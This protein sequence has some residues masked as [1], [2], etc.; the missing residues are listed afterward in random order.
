ML[1]R[2]GGGVGELNGVLANMEG[3]SGDLSEFIMLL[4]CCP[5]ALQRP[6]ATN[7]YADSQCS[8]G[9]SSS[10]VSSTS[11]CKTTM[12]AAASLASFR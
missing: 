11:F 3:I 10:A 9:T 7:I 8:A 12:T 5:P 4:Q 6:L 1:F 2:G